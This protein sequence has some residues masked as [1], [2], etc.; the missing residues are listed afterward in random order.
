MLSMGIFNSDYAEEAFF[1][2]WCCLVRCTSAA[3]AF[4]LEMVCWDVP[5]SKGNWHILS[6]SRCQAAQ[7][8]H[9][10]LCL[11]LSLLSHLQSGLLQL[12]KLTLPV[13]K[14]HLM[15]L[16]LQSCKIV[17]WKSCKERPPQVLSW[18][19]RQWDQNVELLSARNGKLCAKMLHS[20]ASWFFNQIPHLGNPGDWRG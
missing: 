12:S 9:A 4:A 11:L 16:G 8:S 7:L 20:L 18:A 13:C 2:S 3:P 10:N 6:H 17:S 14:K 15:K 19:V 1:F 5:H